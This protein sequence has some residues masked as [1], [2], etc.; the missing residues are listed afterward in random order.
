MGGEEVI[1]FSRGAKVSRSIFYMDDSGT[2]EYAYSADAYS[3]KGNTR[4]FCFG[5]VLINSQRGPLLGRE[6]ANCKKRHF[7]TEEVEIKSN[8]LRIPKERKKRYLDRYGLTEDR[9]G[10][11]VSDL[12]NILSEAEI[13]IL[14]AVVDKEHMQE[15]YGEGAWYPPAICYEVL[16]Q[17][18]VQE[19]PYPNIVSVVVDDMDG[20]TPKGN[21]YKINL[22]K[23]HNSLRKNGSRLRKGLDFRPLQGLKFMDSAKS[24]H[25]QAADI[26]AYNV[27][28]Q[29][30]D[31]GEDWENAANTELPTYEWLAKLAGKFRNKDGR[32]QGYGIIK[33]PLRE[34]IRWGVGA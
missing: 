30:V 13:L 33:M 6:I 4:Y 14:A 32:I 18:L 28:R 12:Y 27:Y 8:W 15:D 24:H 21:Q 3:T 19:I 22:K 26:V 1:N 20:A 9:V 11:F 2:K 29:F 23:Q 5:G 31:H 17:R 10:E 34:R 16:M 7:G 25:V